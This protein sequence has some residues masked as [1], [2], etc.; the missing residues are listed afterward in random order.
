[1]LDC[2]Q[3]ADGLVNV[4]ADGCVVDGGVLNDTSLINDEGTTDCDTLLV[5]YAVSLHDLVLQVRDQG[6][7]EVPNTAL[8]A[9]CL[10]PSQVGELGV[11]RDTEDLTVKVYEFLVAVR[12]GCD[13][14]W[15]DECEVQGVEKE[16]NVFAPAQAKP[17]TF[18]CVLL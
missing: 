15:A 11:N 18:K 3:C 17:K 7:L 12:E 14:R 2:L 5:L 4:T 8:L 9:V 6:V 16:D 13:L 10:D 1:M